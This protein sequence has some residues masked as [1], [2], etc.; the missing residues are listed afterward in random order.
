MKDL[1]RILIELQ[2][3]DLK[4]SKP[5]FRKFIVVEGIYLNHGDIAPLPELVA[6]KT[7]YKYRLIVDES[8]SFGVL[9]KSGKG[10]SDH[11]DIPVSKIDIM[12]GSLTNSLGASGGFVCGDNEVCEHQRLSGQAYTFS[13]SLPA[14]LTVSAITAL[15]IMENEPQLLTRLNENITLFWNCLTKG[16]NSAIFSGGVTQAGLV[17]LIFLRIKGVFRERDDEERVLQDIVDL[18]F[19]INLGSW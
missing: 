16:M 15:K 5:L 8:L 17:P 18:V 11:F 14:L 3:S 12:I 10:L 9:G 4:K 6:L 1:E 19:L 13:A 7:K 2:K